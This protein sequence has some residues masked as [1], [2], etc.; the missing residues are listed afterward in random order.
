MMELLLDIGNH[1]LKWATASQLAG[2]PK[3]TDPEVPNQFCRRPATHASLMKPLI[4]QFAA[5]LDR[6]PQRVTIASVAK[7]AVNDCIAAHCQRTWQVQPQ[8]LAARGGG[9][10]NHYQAGL[11]ID[12]WCAAVAAYRLVGEGPFVVIDAG[13]AITIDY[14]NAARE[15]RGGVICPG[16]ATMLASLNQATDNVANSVADNIAPTQVAVPSH[17]LPLQNDHT[18]AAVTHGVW[19]AGSA[20]VEAA[21]TRFYA[22]PQPP[23]AIVISGGDGEPL[24]KLSNYAMS[25][26]PELVLAGLLILS[27]AKADAAPMSEYE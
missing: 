27:A 15:F 9:L 23:K 25:Y 3:Y 19:L 26:V 7:P 14:V 12:R 13:T 10:T 8:Y 21:L 16:I 22:E 5:R 17:P 6:P 11:G 2:W 18:D 4:S 1:R 24:S 20:A